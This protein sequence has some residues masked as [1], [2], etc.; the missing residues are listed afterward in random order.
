M[1]GKTLKDGN[2]KR[3][4]HG[5]KN[6][7]CKQIHNTIPC[8]DYKCPHNLFWEGLKLNMAKIHMTEKTFRIKNCCCLIHEPWTSEEIATA[9]GLRTKGVQ[10]SERLGWKKAQRKRYS[11]ESNQGIP[12]ANSRVLVQRKGMC[13]RKRIQPAK[14]LL[15]DA[16][17]V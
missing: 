13:R 1:T 12:I 5:G 7:M 4:L 16:L 17:R 10:Q 11:K 14:Q 8:L 9:W 3:I 15:L 6:T 2:Q